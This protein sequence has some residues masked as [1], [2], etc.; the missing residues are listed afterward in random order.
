MCDA[1][2]L[3]FGSQ[4]STRPRDEEYMYIIAGVLG[5]KLVKKKIRKKVN[6]QNDFR[7]QMMGRK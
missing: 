2:F 7:V 6:T 3:Q 4:M 1:L 5:H